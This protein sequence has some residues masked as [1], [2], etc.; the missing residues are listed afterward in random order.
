MLT[1]KALYRNS[2]DVFTLSPRQYS[3]LILQILISDERLRTPGSGPMLLQTQKRRED[4]VSQ[5]GNGAIQAWQENRPLPVQ[6]A[7]Q[8]SLFQRGCTPQFDRHM[9]PASAG[10]AND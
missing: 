5:T 1:T 10:R 9:R 3:I 8:G 2:R 7:L 6:C 4:P